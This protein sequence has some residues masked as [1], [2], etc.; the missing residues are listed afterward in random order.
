M[1][2]KTFRKALFHLSTLGLTLNCNY[3]VIDNVIHLY[4]NHKSTITISG[5]VTTKELIET[6]VANNLAY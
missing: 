3:M 6:M 2:M 4:N 5:N 1:N